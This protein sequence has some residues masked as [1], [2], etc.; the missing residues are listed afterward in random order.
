M[1]ICYYLT[2]M[3]VYNRHR[4]AIQKFLQ[5][6]FDVKLN[7]QIMT[8][9]RVIYYLHFRHVK[10][11]SDK[12]HFRKIVD[13][14]CQHIDQKFW[15]KTK[16]AFYDFRDRMKDFHVFNITWKNI[17]DP[18]LFWKRIII[19]IWFIQSSQYWLISLLIIFISK[20]WHYAYFKFS[21]IRCFS[22]GL[23]QS[24]IFFISKYETILSRLMSTNCSI[25]TSMNVHWKK[26]HEF[27]ENK[28]VCYKKCLITK[29]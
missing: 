27:F 26:K 3:L 9:H 1:N 16:T 17:D 20:H 29:K 10:N 24:W 28:I 18:L 13:F 4:N 21:L 7:K 6:Q 2:Q 22:N 5:T 11:L 23:F 12:L 15:L 19:W 25:F 8:M 14:I